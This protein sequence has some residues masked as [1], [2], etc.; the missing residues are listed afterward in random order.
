MTKSEKLLQTKSP[1]FKGR[2]FNKRKRGKGDNTSTA[3]QATHSKQSK[4]NNNNKDKKAEGVSGHREVWSKSKKKRMRM[5]LAKQKKYATNPEK[6]PVDFQKKKQEKESSA[7]H[8]G[9]LLILD[10]NRKQ[11]SSSS[12]SSLQQAFKARL[13]G[14]R[15]RVLNEELY[16]NTSS[17]SFERFHNDPMLFDEYHQGFRRQVEHWPV[18]PVDVIVASL[19][20][21]AM[22]AAASDNSSSNNNNNKIIVADFGCGDAQLAQQLLQIKFQ[23]NNNNKKECPFQVYSFDLVACSD[24][25]T[26]CDMANVPLQDDV[27]DVVIFCLS[28]MGTNLADFVREAHRVLKTTGKLK[29]AEVRSRF[30]ETTKSSSQ[31][32]QQQKGGKKDDLLNEFIDVLDQLGFKCTKTDR[33]NKMFVLLDLE[34]NGKVPKKNLEFTAKP[35]IYKRR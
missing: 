32:Q 9:Q 1:P 26:A 17:S 4:N 13:S 12:A 16:T 30:F 2:G 18:N 28:L 21:L 5:L 24:L 19:K 27:V 31:Q 11:T 34:K 7:T 23:N 33:T 29:I 22:A 15:F 35:C 14:S 10:N 25:V 20:R 3:T 6:S 8:A